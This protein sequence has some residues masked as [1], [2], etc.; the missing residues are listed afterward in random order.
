MIVPIRTE[1]SIRQTPLANHLLI[2]VNVLC[3]PLLDERAPF[4]GGSLAAWRTQHLVFQTD[5]PGFLQ[6]FT[7]QFLHG[8]MWHLLGNMLFLWVFGNAVNGK[9]GQVPYLLFYL[10]GGAFAAWGWALVSARP[11][12]LIGASG[13][14]AAVTT[15]YLAMFPRSRVTVLVWFFFIHFFELP[16]MVMIGVK[17]IVWDNLVAPRIVGSAGA[18]AHAAHLAG[19][20]F[21]FATALGMLFFRALPRDQF[22]IL[23]LWSRWHRR[24]VFASAM[25]GPEAVGRGRF[26]QV[27]RAPSAD[28][29]QQREDERQLDQLSELRARVGE[30]LQR[31]DVE[32]ALEA[33]E[34]LIAIDPQ[35]CLSEVQQLRLARELYRLGRFPQA[36]AAF[37]RFAE[38]YPRSRE[39]PD[40][41]LLVGIIYARDLKQYETADKRLTQAKALVHDEKRL[42]QCAGWLQT[43]RENMSGS[44]QEE[45]DGADA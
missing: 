9:M 16:A 21:G 43:V 23:A 14:I 44:I 11:A 27:A 20:L 33:F 15:A 37:D 25:S 18:V 30:A 19:Y 6:F 13:A 2:A 7:Y 22:D 39:F 32:S 4:M 8:D 31:C 5:E 42:A 41:L 17:I 28:T 35:Q 26:G 29:Q 1:A 12:H 45:Q 10:A 34:Q 38:C 3:F 36:A 40:V 24:R